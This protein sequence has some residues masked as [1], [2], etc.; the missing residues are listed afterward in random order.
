MWKKILLLIIAVFYVNGISAQKPGRRV[1]IKGIVLDVY[2]AP[3]A[4]AI[5]MVDN[6]KTN[7][8]TDS[9][10]NYKIKVKPGAS[11]IGVFTFG[12]GTIEDYINGRTRIN[13]N[14][15]TMS[16][17]KYNPRF[18]DGE[19]GVNT[20][21]GQVKKRNLTTDV[22]KIDGTNK[23]YASYSSISEMI[24]RE[25]SGVQFFNGDPIIQGSQNF[26]GYIPPLI[27]V[28]GVYMD[29]LA[30]YTPGSS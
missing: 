22:S 8:V 18:S 30:R 21:Y 19:Q 29:H 4:N 10:G 6:K 27:V 1:E 28:D 13:F 17:L 11:K 7:S 23:K 9:R 12:N 20:G 2:H 5:I 26:F 16:T 3:I 14:F 25:V 15:S 24:Q